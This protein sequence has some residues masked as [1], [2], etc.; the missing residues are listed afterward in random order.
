MGAKVGIGHVHLASSRV[1]YDSF[2]LNFFIYFAFSHF[3]LLR[4]FLFGRSLIRLELILP[5]LGS[6]V[7]PITPDY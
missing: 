5:H 7:L 2:L 3:I 1:L 4:D 6:G